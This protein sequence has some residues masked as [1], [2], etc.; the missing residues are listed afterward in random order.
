MR[1]RSRVSSG[2]VKKREKRSS[3]SSR[4]SGF[5]SNLSRSMCVHVAESRVSC[6][7]REASLWGLSPHLPWE[8]LALEFSGDLG[9]LRAAH[10]ACEVAKRKRICHATVLIHELMVLA[11][12]IGLMLAGCYCLDGRFLDGLPSD[13]ECPSSKHSHSLRSFQDSQ[14][15]LK[16]RGCLLW[17]TLSCP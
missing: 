16:S 4:H 7:L 1:R 6:D 17:G 2:S 14:L 9:S 11:W 3:A 8:L 10:V 15:Y 13:Q 5:T 12:Q